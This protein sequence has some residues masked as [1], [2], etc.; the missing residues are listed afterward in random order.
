VNDLGEGSR[1]FGKVALK[2]RPPRTW[3][4]PDPRLSCSAD[5]CGVTTLFAAGWTS[6]PLVRVHWLGTFC[7]RRFCLFPLAAAPV[8]GRVFAPAAA[9]FKL[10]LLGR[11]PLIGY[12][13]RRQG[14]GVHNRSFA[15]SSRS[16]GTACTAQ[17]H[18]VLHTSPLTT[19]DATV[20]R[21]SAPF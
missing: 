13:L 21:R 16:A 2:T 9:A 8:V 1:G 7:K 3:F 17:D 14:T 6:A 12:S 18:S 5:C 20:R 15:A 11:A 19:L 4:Q 10:L